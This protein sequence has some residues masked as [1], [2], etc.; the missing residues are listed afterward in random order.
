MRTVLTLF[1]LFLVLQLNAQYVIEGRVVEA[2]SATPIDFV[3]VLA[4]QNADDELVHGITT[5]NGGQFSI[6]ITIDAVYLELSFI[7]L[8]TKIIRDLKFQNNRVQLGDIYMGED[9]EV[10]EEV[11]VSAERSTTEFKLDKRVFN[12]GSDLSSSGASALDVL[13]NVPSV[14]VNVEGD[15]SL[16]GS[17]GVQILINGKPSILSDD[18]SNAL[19][20]ITAEMMEKVEVITNPSAKYEAEGTA[21]I[22]NIILKKSEKKGTNGSVSINTGYPH[23]HS[24]GLS[25]N[26]RSEKFNVFSQAGMGYREL[27]TDTENINRDI[28]NGTEVSSI[29]EEFRNEIFYNFNLGADY[30]INPLNVLTLSGSLKYEV[31]DQP[32]ETTFQFSDQGQLLSEWNRRE[33]TDA[34]NPKLQYELQYKR[35]FQDNKEHQ[36]LF[37]AIGRY[38]GKDQSSTFTNDFIQGVNNQP[39]QRTATNFDEGKY[40]FNLDYTIPVN[41]KWTL[42]SGAQYLINNVSNDYE[43]RNEDSFGEFVVDESFTNV[44]EYDQ[45]VLGVYSTAAYERSAWGI[46][47]GLRVEN[48]D[49]RTFLVNTSES[50]DQNFT[51]LFPSFHGSYK[52]TDNI[53]FQAGYSRRIFRPR[54]WDLNPFF[55]IRN[56]FNIR[57]GNPNLLPEYTDSYE[58]GVIF[59]LDKISFNSNIYY[60]YTTDKIDRVSN[61][62]DGVN[63]WRPLNIGTNKAPGIEAN[64]KYSPSKKLVFNGDANYNLFIREGELSDQNFDFTA[65][66]WFGKLSSKYKVSKALDVEVTGRYESEV[67]TIQGIQ[68]DNLYADFGLKYKLKGGKSVLNFSVR[69]IFA[70]RVR[71]VTIDQEDLFI[72]SSSQRGRFITLGYSY[73]FGK[74]EAMQFSGRRR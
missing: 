34:T 73:S 56:N 61:F 39:A 48:T 16:R 4:K 5:E 14:N 22:I 72:F 17:S 1:V 12:V 52:F 42:E 58:A 74:G 23:N 70:S 69:D 25:M 60:R 63:F 15:V 68:S 6:D 64:F 62:E 19:G 53:S 8:E 24:V 26:R 20:T 38:F 54:L 30:Y 33:E 2:S 3:T 41:K 47:V 10:L 31:E 29:G 49:L 40:T 36:L 65:N 67:Q 28:L 57:V 9:S 46:K 43:V 51:N 32:S 37:S 45:N 7:G 11:V 50:N 55:N 35:E 66:Q 13:N 27:P 59:I 71:Q 21:G 18:S 44:F